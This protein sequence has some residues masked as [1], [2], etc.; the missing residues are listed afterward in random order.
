MLNFPSATSGASHSS[1]H[2]AGGLF[3]SE[4]APSSGAS[5]ALAAAAKAAA[6]WAAVAPEERRSILRPI[7][8]ALAKTSGDGSG[9]HLEDLVLGADDLAAGRTWPVKQSDFAG[10]VT[11]Q[12]SPRG[13]S[14]GF[15]AEI[16]YK[17]VSCGLE[18]YGSL[19]H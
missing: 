7:V 6:K 18:L 11:V 17:V 15:A 10:N 1:P 2:G 9:C 19:I 16:R 13:K 14:F 8:A 5:N 3:R 4:N 12:R